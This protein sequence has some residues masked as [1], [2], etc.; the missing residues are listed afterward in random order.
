MNLARWEAEQVG[1]E[2]ECHSGKLIFL[3]ES[4]IIIYWMNASLLQGSLDLKVTQQKV[5]HRKLRCGPEFFK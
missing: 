5:T 1:V 4:A 3:Q 2:G